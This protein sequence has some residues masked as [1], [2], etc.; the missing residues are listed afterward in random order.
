MNAKPVMPEWAGIP[1]MGT[2]SRRLEETFFHDDD[3]TF[4]G[5]LHFLGPRIFS[6]TH[7]ARNVEAVKGEASKRDAEERGVEKEPEN[8]RSD[9]F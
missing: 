1:C 9:M 6:M 3:S 8:E 5:R 7:P 4:Q 2:E